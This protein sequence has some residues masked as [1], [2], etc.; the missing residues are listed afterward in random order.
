M[1]VQKRGGGLRTYL[2]VVQNSKRPEGEKGEK[3]VC[4]LIG[5]QRGK[6]R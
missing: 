1:M 3:N 2:K 5:G 6:G 4:Y